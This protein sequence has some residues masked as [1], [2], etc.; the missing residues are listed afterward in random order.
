MNICY[1]K[2]IVFGSKLNYNNYKL[3]QNSKFIEIIL[4]KNDFLFI[5]SGWIHHIITKENT[6]AL[7]YD[8][9]NTSFTNNNNKLISNIL[10]NKPYNKCYD[11]D[12]NYNDFVIN[13]MNNKF[14]FQIS[15]SD[16]FSVV[17]KPFTKKGVSKYYNLNQIYDLKNNNCNFYSAATDIYNKN[18]DLESI[19]FYNQEKLKIIPNFCNFSENNQIN[20]RIETFFNFNISVTTEFH[21]D[22][23][24]SILYVL[25]GEKKVLLSHPKYNIYH[26]ITKFSER[27]FI[28]TPIIFK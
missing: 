10:D 28:Q 23:T 2:S 3:L 6:L 27:P 4:K 12:V 13:N 24:N 16:S 8:I 19:N 15:E 1:G 25:D 9:F 14:K 7:S 5:P 17:D 26:Y 21:C 20:Y 18:L 22:L 11:L